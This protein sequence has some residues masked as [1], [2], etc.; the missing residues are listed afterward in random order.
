MNFWQKILALFGISPKPALVLVPAPKPQPAS[1]APAVSEPTS[2]SGSAPSVPVAPAGSGPITTPQDPGLADV[3]F[4]HACHY[5]MENEDGVDWD[6]DKGE[7]TNDPRDPGGRT[8]W[9]IIQTEYEGFLGRKLSED[10]IKAMPRDTALAIYKKNF[11]VPI[12]GAAFSPVK[13]AAIF[14][15]AVNKGLGGCMVVLSDV[16][17]RKFPTRYGPEVVAAVNGLSDTT[18]LTLFVPAV[19]RYINDRIASYPNM[20]W[21]RKGW[22]NRAVRL[23]TLPTYVG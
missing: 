14:D 20:E 3:S 11:W 23:N 19:E 6:H 18:F 7:Y 13:A 2:S 16:F 17:S 4:L 8:I 21:A 22:T 1:P 10:E 15:T 5:C 12:Q 9:G